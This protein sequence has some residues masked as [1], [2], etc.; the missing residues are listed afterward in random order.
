M[1]E[2]RHRSSFAGLLAAAAMLI[3]TVAGI[4]ALRFFAPDSPNETV[5]RD[6]SKSHITE[7]PAI[8]PGPVIAQ[9]QSPP[10]APRLNSHKSVNRMAASRAKDSSTD[11]ESVVNHQG[12][13]A[14]T[15]DLASGLGPE[16]P[17]AASQPG[18]ETL[19]FDEPYQETSA[20]VPLVYGGDPM[21]TENGPV[22]RVEVSGTMLQSLGFPIAGE[23]STRRVRADLKLGEDGIVRAIRFVQ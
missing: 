5:G 6:F 1:Q 18:A 19:A 2:T 11:G 20:F 16:A 3:V 13:P 23:P 14:N 10:V 12:G 22:V 9:K 17:T 4:L 21:L 7:P 15:A 8:A